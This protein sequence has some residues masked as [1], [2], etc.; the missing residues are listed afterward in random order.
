MPSSL[1]PG[2]EIANVNIPPKGGWVWLVPE[3]GHTV[4]GRDPAHLASVIR[5]HYKMNGLPAPEGLKRRINDFFCASGAVPCTDVSKGTRLWV[6]A[7][8]GT[9]ALLSAAENFLATGESP[10]VS[11]EV[12]ARRA[13]ICASCPLNKALEGGAGCAECQKNTVGVVERALRR[14]ATTLGRL[15]GLKTPHDKQLKVCVDC[16]CE[17]KLKV[18]VKLAALPSRELGSEVPTNCWQR[19][20]L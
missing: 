17:L 1:E 9:D 2:K 8:G 19:E 12:A 20:D 7:R 3:T 6:T 18:H 13:A 4:I 16:G 10:L 14:A 11:S 15:S 5:H